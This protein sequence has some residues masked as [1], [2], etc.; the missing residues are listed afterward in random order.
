MGGGSLRTDQGPVRGLAIRRPRQ[1]S[2]FCASPLTFEGRLAAL[3][4]AH[5]LLTQAKQALAMALALHELCTN[6]V[7]YG[8]L[9]NATGSIA[10][11]WHKAD[12]PEPRSDARRREQGGPPASLPVCR[13]F[14]SCM[15]D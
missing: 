13:G 3:A 9:S 2:A 6:A 1:P 14:G 7:R 10:F 11:E 4:A 12:G 8:A 15:I 5:D